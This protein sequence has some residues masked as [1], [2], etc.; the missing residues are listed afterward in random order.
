[1]NHILNIEQQEKELNEIFQEIYDQKIILFLGAGASVTDEKKYLS[2]ELIEYYRANKSISYD[3]KNDIVDFVDKVFSIKDYDRKD[4]DSN[5]VNFLKN[6][7]FEN[8]HK[9]I[10]EAPWI[11]IIT[12]NID[13]LLEN[14]IENY[15]KEEEFEFIRNIFELRKSSSFGLKQKII[16][17]HGC[18]SDHSKYPLLFSTSDFIKNNKYYDL[19][20]SNLK[21]QSPDIKILFIGYSFSDEFGKLFL[22]KFEEKFDERGYYLLDPF[23]ENE[24]F[25]LNYYSAKRIKIIK[26]FSNLFFEKYA[27]WLL[28]KTAPHKGNIIYNNLGKSI[29]SHLQLKLRI[30]LRPINLNYDNKIISKRN[31]YLGEEPNYNVI[32]HNFDIVKQKKLVEIIK[33]IDE[34]FSTNNR[35]LYPLIYFKGSY[36]SGKTT[37]TYRLISTYIETNKD[38]LAFEIYDLMKFDEKSINEFIE[39]LEGINKIIFYSS[40]TELDL[41]FKKIRE[42]QA[43]LSSQQ[44]QNK[45][46]VFIQSI[47]ENILETYKNKLNIHKDIFEFNVDDILNDAELSQ[48]LD[49]LNEQ[50]LISLRSEKEKAELITNIKVKFQNKQDQFLVLLDYIEKGKHINS[51]VNT[52]KSFQN[53]NTKLAFLYTSILYQYSIKMPVSL[54]KEIIDVDWE[55]FTNDIIKMDGKGIFIQEHYQPENFLETDL[56]FRIKHPIIA[57]RFIEK[58]L[59]INDL[60]KKVKKICNNLPPNESSVYVFINLVKSLISYKVFD[61][62]L[63]FHLYDIAYERLYNF[64]YFILNYS[65]NLQYRKDEKSL[66][67]ALEIIEYNIDSE[68]IFKRNSNFTHRKASVNFALSK[69]YFEYEGGISEAE[70]YYQEA[71][72]LFKIKLNLDP[73][74]IHSYKDYLFMLNWRFNKWKLN[75]EEKLIIEFSARNLIKKANENL[76][77]GIYYINKL[78][79]VINRSLKNHQAIKERIDTLIVSTDTRPYG[80]LLTYDLFKSNPHFLDKSHSEE[81]I[82]SELEFYSFNNEV[83]LFLFHFYSERLNIYNYRMKFYELLKTNSSLKVKDTLNVHFFSFVAE[84]YSHR[85]KDAYEHLKDLKAL[86]PNAIR[87]DKLFWLE[88]DSSEERIFEGT[89]INQNKSYFFKS[90][91][92]GGKLNARVKFDHNQLGKINLNENQKAKIYFNYN[93][94]MAKLVIDENESNTEIIP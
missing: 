68:D 21:Q 36:G 10:I 74:S 49:R 91:E 16:K 89:I 70:E 13:L 14:A 5:T 56:Y 47:R 41:N 29:N 67:K 44:Y 62:T 9:V 23:I 18:I 59:K 2:K 55:T 30:F 1:M 35:T 8:Q 28:N 94:I 48:F 34:I 66:K 46:I 79:D 42:I 25:I 40:N 73:S 86:Y 84:L 83:A 26:S 15:Q 77:E 61:D 72:D 3:P 78:S 50:D 52:Y 82:I 31:Y 64:P 87:K 27:T 24:E 85:Y 11:S 32:K 80:L 76:L 22:N 39:S 93:G 43:K 58:T 81:E 45:Q 37:F 75:E 20:F 7:R 60:I 33:K 92:T 6:L 17:L 71:E 38:C 57:Q 53:E 65:S 69:L 4:F 54:L 90:N 12:T 88:Q 19:I 51:V 63:I